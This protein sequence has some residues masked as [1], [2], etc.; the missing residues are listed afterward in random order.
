MTMC[1]SAWLLLALLLVGLSLACRGEGDSQKNQMQ[2]K[3]VRATVVVIEIFREKLGRRWVLFLA[4][5]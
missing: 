2:P 1:A 3:P 5:T 4:V